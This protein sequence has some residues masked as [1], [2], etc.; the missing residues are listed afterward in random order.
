M[1]HVA[2]CDDNS[3]FLS[4]FKNQISSILKKQNTAYKID[5]FSNIPEF[6]QETKEGTIYQ[7]VF[8]DIEFPNTTKSGLYGADYVRT[9][10]SESNTHIVFISGQPKYAMRLFDYQPLQFLIKPINKNKLVHTIQKSV[11]FWNHSNTIFHF[12]SNRQ[13][14][15]IEI[16]QILYIEAYGRKKLLH[17][18]SGKTYTFNNSFAKILNQLE[19]YNFFSPHK[20]YIVNYTKVAVWQKETM[21]MKNGDVI[22]IGRSQQKKVQEIQLKHFFDRKGLWI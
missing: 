6:I 2:V 14:I 1:F 9:Y 17:C 21:I 8:M 20:S 22:P 4:D 11:D 5:C 13:E 15:T 19:P 16:H 18:I 3:I 7:L 10:L 12:I